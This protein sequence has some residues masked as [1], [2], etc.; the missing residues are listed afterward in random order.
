MKNVTLITGAS[1]GL[2]L[3]FAKSYAKSGNNLVLVSRNEAKLYDIKKELENKYGVTI[4][5]YKKDL[6]KANAASDIY[7]FVMK[8]QLFVNVLI[9][10]AGFGDYG[11]FTNSDLKKQ[12][13]MVHVNILSVMEM[14]YFFAKPMQEKDTGV[15]LNV[16]SVAGFQSGPLMSVYYAT[17]AFVLSFTEALSVEMKD[18]GVSIKALCPGP[19]NTGFVSAAQLEES[20][21]FKHLKNAT[22]KE[23]V[24]YAFKKMD[25][26]KVVL[27]PGFLNKVMVLSSKIIPRSVVRKIVYL[28]QR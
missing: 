7:D 13:N 15:I 28:I 4:Y 3:E 11:K 12:N 1:G 20:G 6:S 9:N 14:C 2:G 18:T 21:L 27:I 26:K 5:V 16:C 19:T 22:A 23:V 17:K 25:N 24:Q 8:K 10:N